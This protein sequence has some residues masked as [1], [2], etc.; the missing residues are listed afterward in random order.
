[1]PYDAPMKDAKGYLK[2]NEIH[3]VI[4]AADN[5]RNKILLLLLWNAGR[6]ISELV[7]KTYG[8]RK[9]DLDMKNNRI[10]FTTLKT[11]GRERM[12]VDGIDPLIM[13]GLWE[14]CKDKK[15]DEMVFDIGRKM[16]YIIFRDACYKVGI[17]QIGSKRPHPHHM[18]HSSIMFMYSKG[19]K[20]EEIQQR[21]GHRDINS[22]LYYIKVMELENLTDKFKEMWKEESNWLKEI[23]K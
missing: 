6:R 1:M 3:P 18:R 10:Y 12:W 16:G 8:I 19:M 9:K 15:D 5:K 23:L 17:R 7:D 20:P 14:L 21:T 13:K 11:K 2:P 4:E 22:L